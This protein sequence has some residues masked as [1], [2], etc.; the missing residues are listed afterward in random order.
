VGAQNVGDGAGDRGPR[1]SAE[2]G[3]WVCF[4][5]C[6]SGFVFFISDQNEGRGPPHCLHTLPGLGGGDTT[7][8]V[9][10]LLSGPTRPQARG[11]PAA[12]NLG[13]GGRGRAVTDIGWSYAPRDG[14]FSRGE[15]AGALIGGRLAGRRNE[16]KGRGGPIVRSP[17]IGPGGPQDFPDRR[18]FC[19][20]T[21]GRTTRTIDFRPTRRSNGAGPGT[22][23]G[24]NRSSFSFFRAGGQGRLGL[25]GTARGGR[26]CPAKGGGITIRPSGKAH[27]SPNPTRQLPPARL[28]TGT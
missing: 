16:K 20:T 11:A 8:F 24:L 13:P 4:A 1:F 15:N 21:L 5:G 9:Y 3:F 17:P 14:T 19:P 28:S 7:R 2:F 23:L 12:R 6:S 27:R 22:A 18:I 26:D 10:R 25:K